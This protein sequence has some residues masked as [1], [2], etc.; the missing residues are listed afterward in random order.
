MDHHLAKIEGSK[1]VVV[2]KKYFFEL[3]AFAV[4][5]ALQTS[6][7]QQRPRVPRRVGEAFWATEERRRP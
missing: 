3:Y 5:D 1:K 6:R 2:S 7:V 4:D